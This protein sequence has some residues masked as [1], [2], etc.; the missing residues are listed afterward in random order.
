MAAHNHKKTRDRVQAIGTHTT[1]V[2]AVQV[3]IAENEVGDKGEDYSG[4]Q[5]IQ[6][7][8]VARRRPPEE[9]GGD[10]EEEDDV[11]DRI[12]QRESRH[13]AVASS[14]LRNRLEKEIPDEHPST[15]CHY[16]GI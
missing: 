13:Y 10:T 1:L 15:Q 2:G 16:P 4:Q 6:C 8:A 3:L 9:H 5:K 7:Q 12:G 14:G 11:T